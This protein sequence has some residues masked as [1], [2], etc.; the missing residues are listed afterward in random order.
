MSKR[1]TKKTNADNGTD[2]YAFMYNIDPRRLELGSPAP[3]SVTNV[4]LL[5]YNSY[6]ATFHWEK[7]NMTMAIDIPFIGY[8]QLPCRWA[9][10]LKITS[11]LN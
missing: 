5:G 1:Y 7:T 4:T 3:S 9:W 6:P 11:V 2:I 8:Y 10:V